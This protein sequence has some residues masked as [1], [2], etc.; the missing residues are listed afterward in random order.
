MEKN[1]YEATLL[2]DWSELGQWAWQTSPKTIADSGNE[3][4]MTGERREEKE[5]DLAFYVFIKCPM[6]HI[7]I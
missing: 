4:G 6:R 1:T 7:Q 5:K 3:G 2:S